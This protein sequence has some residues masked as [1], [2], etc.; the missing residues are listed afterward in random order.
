MFQILEHKTSTSHGELV[1]GL[2]GDLHHQVRLYE[3][4]KQSRGMACGQADPL[5]VTAKG[6]PLSNSRLARA[7]RETLLRVGAGFSATPNRFRHTV[8][9]LVK[10]K[11]QYK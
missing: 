11:Y 2:P 7:V 4:M 3:K 6:V 10:L 5:L 8:V 1:I 9:T